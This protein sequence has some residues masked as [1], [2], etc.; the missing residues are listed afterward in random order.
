MNIYD[1]FKYY[2]CK[3]GR[4]YMNK[5]TSAI[6]NT[7]DILE[8][9]KYL[10]LSK[11]EKQDWILM[12]K[13]STPQQE[14]WA[15]KFL[16]TLP[17]P[18]KNLIEQIENVYMKEFKTAFIHGFHI[19]CEDNKL[20]GDYLCFQESEEV[21]TMV[22]WCKKNNISYYIESP[23]EQQVKRFLESINSD[24]KRLEFNAKYTCSDDY[25]DEFELFCKENGIWKKFLKFYY[26]EQEEY[27]KKFF[28]ERGEKYYPP[29]GMEFRLKTSYE[30]I[31]YDLLKNIDFNNYKFEI[32]EEEIIYESDPERGLPPRLSG[33][34][35]KKEISDNG[36]YLVVFLNLQ[37]YPINSEISHIETYDDFLNSDCELIL[38]FSDNEFIE[39]YTKRPSELGD[40]VGSNVVTMGV[41]YELKTREND[42]R[43]VMKV[44]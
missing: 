29:I 34:E 12:P 42:G 13:F 8:K 33:I 22:R 32:V 5:N 16:K 43:Y 9:K 14:K 7:S 27:E 11:K 37:V 26:E 24:G 20:W 17:F 36:N 35:F 44:Y 19:F 3:Q 6:F 40:M 38:L 30:K 10:D 1:L 31:L 41:S 18:Y 2:Y 25:M 39:I 23:E 4:I 15:R 21:K 28:E